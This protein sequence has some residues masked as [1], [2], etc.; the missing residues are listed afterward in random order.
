MYKYLQIGKE[1]FQSVFATN[2][3]WE[4]PLGRFPWDIYGEPCYTDYHEVLPLSL[5][6]C[7]FHE[8]NCDNGFCIAM[9][10]RCD[11]SLDCSDKTGLP[12]Q[13]NNESVE[14]Y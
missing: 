11:G 4:F 7:N 13:L 8:F 2:P 3:D 10:K 6:A 12:V 14:L 5:N 1:F 9:E